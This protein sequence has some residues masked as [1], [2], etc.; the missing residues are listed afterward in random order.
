MATTT[1]TTKTKKRLTAKELSAILGER[2]LIRGGKHLKKC[3][4]NVC[5]RERLAV[6]EAR[7]RMVVAGGGRPLST[8]HLVPVRAHFRNQPSYLRNDPILK[9]LAREVAQQL[10]LLIAAQ[11]Q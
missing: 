11:K 2:P 10:M 5:V 3:N 9:E 6:Y 1:R 4:C 8:E 7:A